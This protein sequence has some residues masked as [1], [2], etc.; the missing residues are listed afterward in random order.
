[1]KLHKENYPLR[2]IVNET[3]TWQM[4]LGEF[5]QSGLKVLKIDDPFRV[6]NSEQVISKLEKYHEKSINCVSFDA[7]EMFFNMDQSIV[8]HRNSKRCNWKLWSNRVPK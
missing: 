3:G 8:N 6:I 4:V 1:M 2:P 5:L 7:V